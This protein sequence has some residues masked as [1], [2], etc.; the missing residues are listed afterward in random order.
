MYLLNNFFMIFE[1]FKIFTGTCTYECTLDI[2]NNIIS[3]K[4]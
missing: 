1:K 2:D 4:V 3:I